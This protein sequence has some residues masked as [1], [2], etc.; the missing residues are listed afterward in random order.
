MIEL[1]K[2]PNLDFMGFRKYAY[3]FSLAC[4]VIALLLIFIKGPRLGVDFTGGA[5]IWVRFE[6]TVETGDIRVSLGKIGQAQ[7]SI[8]KLAGTNEFVIRSVEKKD[9][10]KFA[11]E[12][13]TR[14]KL[15]FN[16][17]L[18]ELR[19]KETVEP[20]ISQELTRNTIFAV[21][22]CLFLMGV[23]VWFRFDFRFGAAS[24]ISLF[25][26][27]LITTGALVL[28]GRE[29][30]IP[31]IGALLT[32]LGYSIN[33]TIVISDRVRE[34]YKKMRGLPYRDLINNS[35][36]ETFSRTV[37]TGTFVIISLFLLFF[38]G[39]PVIAD[40]AFTLIVG[41]IFGTYSSTFVVCA[42]VVDWNERFPKKGKK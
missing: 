29:F 23:Y 7:A 38:V 3:I 15:D 25:H 42:L 4:V 20:K 26:D 11:D 21:L 17:N 5:L 1:V 35:V 39:G 10:A 12:V 18:P 22:L 6:K 19:A 30:T 41:L 24:V 27:I 16:D 33:D 14:L 36:N 32:I 13:I 2:N 40:F 8:Q 34:D 28:T 9:P 31:V 37:L